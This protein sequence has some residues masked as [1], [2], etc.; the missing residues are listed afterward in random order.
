MGEAGALVVW[1]STRLLRQLGDINHL[2]T[3]KPKYAQ[4]QPIAHDVYTNIIIDW[5]YFAA[6]AGAGVP[7]GAA[8]AAAAGAGAWAPAPRISFS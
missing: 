4:P 8:A 1:A 2:H 3:I 7:A 5:I 6:A